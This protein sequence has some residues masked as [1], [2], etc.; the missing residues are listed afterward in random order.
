MV[1]AMRK[2]SDNVMGTENRKSETR[3]A[4][5]GCLHVKSCGNNFRTQ[6][7]TVL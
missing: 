1:N 3:Q 2:M 7:I 4:I 6:V 5:R